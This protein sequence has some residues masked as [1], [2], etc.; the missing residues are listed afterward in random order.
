MDTN[1]TITADQAAVDAAQATLD[2]DTATLAAAKDKLAADTAAASAPAPDTLSSIL[3]QI[4]AVAVQLG[5]TFTDAITALVAK[6]KAL[7]P[8]A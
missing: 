3:D 6:A 7:L 2:A 5:S 1:D 4:E 8:A